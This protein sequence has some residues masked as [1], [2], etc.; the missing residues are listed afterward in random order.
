MHLISTPFWASLND[1]KEFLF[2]GFVFWVFFKAETHKDT[3]NGR[4]KILEIEK[5]LNK[6]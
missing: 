4:N 1:S 5:Y 2:W 3:E 6:W